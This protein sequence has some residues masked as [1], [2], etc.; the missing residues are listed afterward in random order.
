MFKIFFSIILIQDLLTGKFQFC[1]SH[2]VKYFD[3][4]ESLASSDSC[5]YCS[6]TP[7]CQDPLD[8]NEVQPRGCVANSVCL[9]YTTMLKYMR[10]YLVSVVYFIINMCICILFN[11]WY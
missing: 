7:Q 4:L 3:V 8:F 9:K 1:H 5:F 2:F 10:K 11:F 6:G